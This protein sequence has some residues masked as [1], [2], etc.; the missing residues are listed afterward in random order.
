MVHSVILCQTL[1]LPASHLQW[2]EVPPHSPQVVS[3]DLPTLRG[4]ALSHSLPV[5]F[6]KVIYWQDTHGLFTQ[7]CMLVCVDLGE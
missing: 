7:S 3:D 1:I 5:E 6:K 4:T 2:G